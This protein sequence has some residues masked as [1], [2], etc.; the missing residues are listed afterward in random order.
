MKS[1][2]LENLIQCENYLLSIFNFLNLDQVK[3]QVQAR[4][5]KKMTLCRSPHIDKKSREQ[6]QILTHRKT[7][8]CCFL[9]KPILLIFLDIVKDL[10]CIGIELELLIDYPNF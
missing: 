5:S 7:L 1:F 3:H 2:D 4:T 8:V 9:S 10:K 6:F